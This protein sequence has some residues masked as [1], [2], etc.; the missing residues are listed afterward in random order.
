MGGGN[1]IGC[2]PILNF[3]NEAQRLEYLPKVS[4]GEI[5]FC[6]G[7]T[8]PDSEFLGFHFDSDDPSSERN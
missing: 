3:G 5:T 4:R 8:E 1:L 6:L 2:P 7:I